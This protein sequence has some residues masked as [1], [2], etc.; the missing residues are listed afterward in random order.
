[1][2]ALY[3]IEPAIPASRMACS[4]LNIELSDFPVQYFV[5]K[6]NAYRLVVPSH[7]EFVLRAEQTIATL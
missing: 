3:C 2:M 7:F 5:T 4:N 1:M 6:N